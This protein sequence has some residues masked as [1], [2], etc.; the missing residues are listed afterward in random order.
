MDGRQQTNIRQE[1]KQE[2]TIRVSM[3]Q[4]LDSQLLELGDDDLL[5]RIDN[6]INENGALEEGR[7]EYDDSDIPAEDEEY[8]DHRYDDD[9]INYNVDSEELPVYTPGGDV[10]HAEIPIGETKSFID[11]LKEQLAEQEI[12]SDKQRTLV[13]YLIASLDDNGFV[14]RPLANIADDLLLYHNIDVSEDDLHKAL[15]VIQRLDPPGIGARNLQECMTIQLDRKIDECEEEGNERRVEILSTGKAIVE[16]YFEHFKRNDRSQIAQQLN[17]TGDTVNDAFAELTR[18]NPRPGLSLNE[19]SSG[20]EQA[21]VPDFIIETTVDGNIS[22]TLRGGKIPPL[23]VN[24]EYKAM[25]ENAAKAKLTDSQKEDLKYIKQNVERAQGFINAIHKRQETLAKTMKAIIDAQ[26]PFML[27]QDDAD[28]KPLTGGEIAK[29]IGMDGST[30]SRAVSNRYAL[31]DGT[32]YPLKDFFLRTKRNAG[33]E[34]VLRTQVE[35]ALTEIIDNEDKS[36]PLN[37]T[38]ISK[39]LLEKG[40]NIQRRTVAKYRSQ[41]QIPSANMRR[42]Y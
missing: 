20:K 17:L 10:A 14:D 15:M 32:L 5:V 21:V 6:E 41:L 1:A 31:L 37:D 8:D 3:Q 11:E 39:K 13:E 27:S 12:E 7:E 25:V 24:S 2:A 36:N 16:K 33:G 38:E 18:L 26:R 28:L 35:A 19:S 29:R 9:D 30:V 23:R 40:L 42:K 4:V 22:F 34:E